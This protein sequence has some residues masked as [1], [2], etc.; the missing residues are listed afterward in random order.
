MT[1]DLPP[2]TLEFYNWFYSAPHRIKYGGNDSPAYLAAAEAWDAAIA[3]HEA[4]D[5]PP[6]PEP[7]EDAEAYMAELRRTVHA[8]AAIAA[9][10]S[11]LPD[12]TRS[13]A[14]PVSADVAA[15]C[16][17]IDFLIHE[18]D[19]ELGLRH[20]PELLAIC[21]DMKASLR[22]LD[23]QVR[24]NIAPAAVSAGVAAMCVE[25]GDI[26]IHFKNEGCAASEK[27]CHKAIALLRSRDARVAELEGL[28]RAEFG[29]PW[30]AAQSE[31]KI[32]AAPEVPAPPDT[33]PPS[34]QTP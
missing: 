16:E 15:M 10:K 3:A 27:E 29:A 32:N 22:S 26:A 4:P 14:Q 18:L 8:R 17:R 1:T 12:A 20:F 34:R 6:L 13:Q 9:D 7:S 5:L 11:S 30:I 28:L 21:E 31:G 24:A 19:R 25:L 33:P 23:A 2:P